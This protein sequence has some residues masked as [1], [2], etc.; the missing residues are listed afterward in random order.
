MNF[1]SHTSNTLTKTRGP[2][3]KMYPDDRETKRRCHGAVPVA[4]TVLT[5]ETGRRFGFHLKSNADTNNS[6]DDRPA[7]SKDASL[8]TEMQLFLAAEPGS[9]YGVFGIKIPLRD[10]QFHIYHS[11]FSIFCSHRL[12]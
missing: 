8:G 9:Y 4:D 7:A 3:A 6:R 10:L 1:A 2:R 5:G 11:A 12:G